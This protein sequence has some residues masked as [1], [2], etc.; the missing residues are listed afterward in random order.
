MHKLGSPFLWAILF[1]RIQSLHWSNKC[2]FGKGFPQFTCSWNAPPNNENVEKAIYFIIHCQQLSPNLLCLYLR[3]S[4]A[5]PTSISSSHGHAQ[6]FQHK[7]KPSW[8]WTVTWS[9]WG[10][11]EHQPVRSTVEKG[12]KRAY[13]C[14]RFIKKVYFRNIGPARESS[15]GILFVD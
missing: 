5:Y 3:A 13:Q 2:Q 10:R 12:S 4:Q 8:L 15:S 9:W 14:F 7:K 6:S 11:Y 1:N